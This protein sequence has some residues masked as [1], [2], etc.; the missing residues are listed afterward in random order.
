MHCGHDVRSKFRRNHFSPVLL[1]PESHLREGLEPHSPKAHKDL[2]LHNFKL[3]VEP[4]AH[5]SIPECQGL[6]WTRL[7]PRCAATHL[8]CL[9]ASVT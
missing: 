2:W 7:L 8:K 4:W 5:A 3:G 6:L 1:L 9:T